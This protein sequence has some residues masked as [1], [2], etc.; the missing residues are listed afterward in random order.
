MPLEQRAGGAEFL[1]RL[2]GAE[3]ERGVHRAYIAGRERRAKT[4][5]AGRKPGLRARR[6]PRM[7]SLDTWRPKSNTE[8]CS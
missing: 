6:A 5:S 1:E 7:Y 4:L 8:K 2:F 3:I